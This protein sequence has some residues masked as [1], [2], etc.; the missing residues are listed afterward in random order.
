MVS[1]D[2]DIHQSGEVVTL[3]STNLK[4]YSDRPE[5]RRE[6]ER[7]KER[8]GERDCSTS[9]QLIR[10][11]GTTGITNSLMMTGVNG[12]YLMSFLPSQGRMVTN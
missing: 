4:K 10:S 1:S 8:E 5:R 9:G 12:R 7:E 6:R 11:M 2:T 3:I